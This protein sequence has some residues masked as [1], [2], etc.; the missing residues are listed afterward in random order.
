MNLQQTNHFY[1]LSI[2]PTR[3]FSLRSPL[4]GTFPDSNNSECNDYKNI[5]DILKTVFSYV[6]YNS[7]KAKLIR[8]NFLLVEFE[9]G[10][11]NTDVVE[12]DIDVEGFPTIRINKLKIETCLQPTL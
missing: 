6:D 9:E 12:H 4:P 11:K 1:K 8:D 3:V 7:E 10:S 2:S 5:K